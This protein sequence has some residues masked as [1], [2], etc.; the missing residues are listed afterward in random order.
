EEVT[1]ELY[2]AEFHQGKLL[3]SYGEFAGEV[4]ED[5]RE[6][7]RDQYRKQGSFDAMYD[8]PEPVVS[9][10]GGKVVVAEQETWFLRYNDEEWKEKAREAV[11]DLDAIPENTREEYNH[12]IDWLEE[13]PCIRNYGLGT[14]LPWDDD[15]IIEPLSDSTIYM[16]YYTIAHRIQDIPIDELNDE[17]FDTLLLGRGDNQYAQELR[18][19][20][21][22]WY[23]VDYRCSANDLITNHLTFYLFHHAELF[24]QTNWPEGITVMGMGLL[25][26]EKMSSSKG[27]VV[28]PSR[29]LDE[30]GADTIRFFLLN[31]AEPWQDYDWRSTEVANTRDQLERF[32]SQ[33]MEVIHQDIPDAEPHLEPID[34]WILSRLQDTIQS[35]T[36]AMEEFETRR[37]SQEAFYRFKEDLRWYR[38]RTDLDRP[39]A[40]WTRAEV[41]RKRLR[42]LAPFIP[43]LTNELHESLTGESAEDASWPKVES[44]RRRQTLE[45]K[46]ELIENLLDDIRDI[47]EVT[48]KDPSTIHIYTAADWKQEV[49]ETMVDIGPDRGAIMREIMSQESLRERGDEVNDLVGRLI[50]TV[51]ERDDSVLADLIK[52]NEEEIYSSAAGFIGDEFDASV[53]VKPEETVDEE[54]TED[55]IPFR[56]AIHLN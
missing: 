50:D 45:I 54:W 52:M 8:F 14:P 16:A 29:A 7:F 23:P 21:E 42:L 20:F 22:H 37:A 47:I 27:H 39:G 28:L 19:E 26:G 35:T 53:V 18:D 10:A 25:E 2:N 6:R 51:R 1:Q 4:I 12:T 36:N 3:D 9:R 38:R 5:V 15:F 33:A 13:W 49:L 40:R 24:E 34:E 17:F 31:S 41:L 56:P 46:E 11:D 30:Y 55:A 44:D 43:F 32:W 48:G